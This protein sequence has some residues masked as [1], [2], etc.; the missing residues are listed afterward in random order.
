MLCF[1][2]HRYVRGCEA[3]GEEVVE[4][5]YG[6][7]TR[8]QHELRAAGRVAAMASATSAELPCASL[9]NDR[10][11]VS[12]PAAA[13]GG[14]STARVLTGG[15]R[16][17][18]SGITTTFDGSIEIDAPAGGG[19]L[20]RTRPLS[21]AADLS[22]GG[23]RGATLPLSAAVEAA[24]A[25]SERHVLALLREAASGDDS[26]RPLDTKALLRVEQ[27]LRKLSAGVMANADGQ[28]LLLDLSRR[29][30]PSVDALRSSRAGVALKQLSKGH[31]LSTIS[32]L[33]TAVLAT[34]K[35]AAEREGKR[36]ARAEALHV[37]GGGDDGPGVA[38]VS[39][40]GGKAEAPI[41]STATDAR[42]GSSLDAT[43]QT[44]ACV[45]AEAL[46]AG[47]VADGA[48]ASGGGA[49]PARDEA[50]LGALAS[51]LEQALYEGH[52]SATDKAYRGRARV[53]S[54]VLRSSRGVGLRKRLRDG[55]LSVQEL[56]TLDVSDAML[57]DA[58]RRKR[59]DRKEREA[60][61]IESIRI[62][63]Q[64]EQTDAYTCEQCRSRRCA[65]FH[66]NSM[67]AVHLTAVPDII[68][69][70]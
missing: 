69:D 29:P 36:R 49:E 26:R 51:R 28:S 1:H 42:S 41:K 19:A 11:S 10:E 33:A 62:G 3:L 61:G 16:V 70:W 63:N 64:S 22:M 21:S 50:Q 32:A 14:D 17:R 15:Y 45:L 39:R 23:E 8:L 27:Q 43:R 5:P 67:G 57:T 52:G 58:E 48:V 18:A 68:V 40:D 24:A 60:R 65:L 38:K 59:Q 54:G 20:I 25:W 2:A 34:W 37:D 35:A 30:P 56:C 44:A 55:E 47:T 4:L 12:R 66:T 13:S 9:G 46:R 7:A 6:F 53:L 31:G